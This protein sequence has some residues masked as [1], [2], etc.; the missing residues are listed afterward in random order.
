MKKLPKEQ[1]D[2]TV[3]EEVLPSFRVDSADIP[4]EPS[5]NPLDEGKKIAP[6]LQPFKI[7]TLSYAKKK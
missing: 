5:G 7:E 6:L 1:R 2:E 3:R 4:V